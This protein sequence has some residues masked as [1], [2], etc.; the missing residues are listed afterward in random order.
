MCPHGA[1]ERQCSATGEEMV[2]GCSKTR[3]KIV[4]GA[5]CQRKGGESSRVREVKKLRNYNHPRNEF[6]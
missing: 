4:I 3:R 5:T 1:K 6:I 2:S